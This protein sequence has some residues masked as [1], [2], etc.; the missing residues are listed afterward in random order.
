MA[1]DGNA[2]AVYDTAKA[3]LDNGIVEP[4]KPIEGYAAY[5]STKIYVAGDWVTYNGKVFEAY[6][7]TLGDV[8]DETQQWRVWRVVSQKYISISKKTISNSCHL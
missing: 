1:Y 2:G 8:P 4:E 7:W 3:V 6:W 5:D